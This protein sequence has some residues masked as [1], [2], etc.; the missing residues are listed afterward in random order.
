MKLI[1]IAVLFLAASAFAQAEVSTKNL[2]SNPTLK[3]SSGSLP[4]GWT[5]WSPRP[6][7][8][9]TA[10]VTTC[11]GEAALSLKAKAYA[12]YG[13][14]V[15][16]VK[17][18][19]GGKFYRFDAWH[20]ASGVETETVSVVALL[21]WCRN[22]DGT[23]ELQRD[24]VEQ[25]ATTG[26]WRRNTRTLRAPDGTQSMRV[27]LGLRWTK[28][29]S[30]LW[31]NISLAEVPAPAPRIV[32]VV[33]T[34]VM[35]GAVRTIENNKKLMAQMFD[36]AA[37]QKPDVILFSEGLVDRSVR[38]PLEK[39]AETIPGPST[40]LLSERARKYHCYVITTLHERD[41]D[42]YYNTA[43]L[44]D[45][46][47]KIVGKYRKVHLA[48][49][50]SDMGLTP[51]NEYPVFTTDFGRI[52]ILTCWDDW[53]SEPARILRLRGAEI[54]FHPLAGDGSD[55][56]WDAIS[57]ARAIDNGLFFVSSGTVS[58]ASRIINPDGEVLAEARGD[59]SY[60]V[61]DIDLNQEWRWRYLSVGKG[62]GEG[63][64]LYT[65]ERRPDTY[66]DLTSATLTPAGKAKEE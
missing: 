55:G 9:P 3:S 34:R 48:L 54:L 63:K 7:L 18:I 2:I 22:P 53:F 52:G 62:T 16:L 66:S 11:D 64:T 25:D 19:E 47:G 36:I 35:P 45:R 1:S 44:I 37:E 21:C 23:E 20:Q 6:G 65:A 30:V 14:W 15:S 50:E 28:G 8:A 33:T 57:R 41:G 27:E 49:A 24:Y 40:D 5:L 10:S 59:F 26:D 60:A 13:R 51:G 4:E 61:K 43:V 29:G 31:K 46:S 56:H 32:R 17:G 39:K 12:D 42:L 58:D 38:L